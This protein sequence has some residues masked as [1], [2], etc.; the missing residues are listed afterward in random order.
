MVD[1]LLS[2]SK[3]LG[4]I[5]SQGGEGRKKAEREESGREELQRKTEK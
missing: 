2:V 5:A 4:S 1:C 3:V